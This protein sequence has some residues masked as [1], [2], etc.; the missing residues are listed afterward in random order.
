MKKI[1]MLLVLIGATNTFA[2]SEVNRQLKEIETATD[3]CLEQHS[4]TVGMGM[5]ISEEEKSLDKLLN[6]TYQGIKNNL[7]RAHSR[8]LVESEKDWL[9]LR[10]SN[11]KLSA[12]S[13]IGG[14]M[15]SLALVSCSNQMTEDRIIKLLELTELETM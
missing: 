2:N 13:V 12:Y 11:C 15:Y 6:E 1:V 14:S 10:T 3:V 7:D 5:C 4:S 8:L 9:K